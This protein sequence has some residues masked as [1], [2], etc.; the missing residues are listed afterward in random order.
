[1]KNTA[2][3]LL[4]AAVFVIFA[5]GASAQMK[6]SYFMEG[7][8]QR[9]E[10]NPALTPQRGYVSVVPFT[11]SGINFNNNFLSIS[12]FIYP[13][14]GGHVTFMHSSVDAGKFMNS[15][16]AQPDFGID[17]KY[18]ITSFG[19]YGRNHRYFWSFD[20]NI[21]TITDIGI[22]KDFFRVLKNLGNGT[23]D[24]GDLHMNAMAYSEMALGFSMPV[25]WDNLTVGGR[26]KFL[27]GLGHAEAHMSTLK[28]DIGEDK[29]SAMADGTIRTS[30]AGMDFSDI[31]VGD[32]IPFNSLFAH[33]FSV[34]NLAGGLGIGA[35]IDLG[36]ELK[37]LGDHLKL[38]VALNDL[39]F[40]QWGR[41]SSIE[42][43]LDDILFEY[44]GYN[45]ALNG[46]DITMP[47]G[48]EITVR[49]TGNEGYSKRLATNLNI[50]A[51]WNF[52]DNLL[53]LGVLSHTKFWNGAAHSELTLTGTVR[54]AKWFTAS[55]SHTLIANKFGI[56]GAAINFHPRGVNIF[57]GMDY[58][59]AQ[60]AKFEFAL[61][62]NARDRVGPAYMIFPSRLK[63]FNL[64][65]G[66]AFTLGR[67][68]PW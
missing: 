56:F 36:A 55:L 58:I 18:S 13:Y 5:A 10:M 31:A 66:F 24:M 38:S 26:L 8:I 25:V 42:G 65:M 49:K 45:T 14:Q 41:R 21:R 46:V 16:P 37:L 50:G 61:D 51:E 9:Y 34:N 29:V 6:T 52:F 44:R 30:I 35:A 67:E 17:Y 47:D 4:V 12:N 22:P 1:M 28:L 59:P 32:P 2:Y 3:K 40:I 15:L 57:M 11:Q 53:G 33:R 27:V 60:Y 43:D 68:K 39:G 64:Y 19:K 62:E 7:S 20:W 63:S 48:D 23:F 54:P